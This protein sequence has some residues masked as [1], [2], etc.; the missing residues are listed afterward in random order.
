MSQREERVRRRLF[1]QIRREKP[2]GERD[3]R[4]FPIHAPGVTDIDPREAGVVHD[5]TNETIF[6][7][8]TWSSPW[9]GP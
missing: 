2:Y 6:G 3:E 1:A 8:A 9:G 7:F 4:S 5:Q